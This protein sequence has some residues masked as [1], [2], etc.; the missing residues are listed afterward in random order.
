[1]TKGELRG[2]NRAGMLAMS[3]KGRERERNADREAES[4]RG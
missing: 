3:K 4:I 2:L 1:V